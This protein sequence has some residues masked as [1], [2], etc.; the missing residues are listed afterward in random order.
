MYACPDCATHAPP[1]T[2]PL[3]TPNATHRR[4]R[5]TLRVYK[6][7]AAGTVTE[8]C[9]KVEIPADEHSTPVPFMSAYPPCACSRC[10]TP[11]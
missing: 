8:D 5:L 2:D 9:G 1:P 4:S 7:D 6:I 3:E 10:R 11:H